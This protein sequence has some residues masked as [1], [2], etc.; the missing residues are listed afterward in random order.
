MRMP[1]GGAT[2]VP[3][4]EERNEDL[5]HNLH[6]TSP[7]ANLDRE[8]LDVKVSE[9]DEGNTMDFVMADKRYTLQGVR[10]VK[11]WTLNG[12]D[13]HIIVRCYV[14]LRCLN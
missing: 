9:E 10:P 13:L 6:P 12:G 11:D 5:L 14:D 8:T 1:S 4:L 7:G 3:K 2:P